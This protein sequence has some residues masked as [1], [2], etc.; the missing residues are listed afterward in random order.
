LTGSWRQAP[1]HKSNRPRLPV[2]ESTRPGSLTVDNENLDD[3]ID[4]PQCR[5]AKSAL[6][7]ARFKPKN[8][9]NPPDSAPSNGRI[10]RLGQAMTNSECD[11]TKES[12]IASSAKPSPPPAPQSTPEADR[13][14]AISRG[15]ERM[16][17]TAGERLRDDPTLQVPY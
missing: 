15:L 9:H 2:P 14:E 7:K 10:L 5:N 17:R 11:M 4:F 1:L 12:S 3:A 16:H 13:Q 8:P 6:L